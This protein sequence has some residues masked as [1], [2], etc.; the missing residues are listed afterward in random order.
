MHG[1]RKRQKKR[2]RSV[3]R[4]SQGFA[5]RAERRAEALALLR[6]AC[7][8]VFENSASEAEFRFIPGRMTGQCHSGGC[9]VCKGAVSRLPGVRLISVQRKNVRTEPFL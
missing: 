2:E 5:E 1:S 8:G 7:F 3:G 6:G 9:G 4:A